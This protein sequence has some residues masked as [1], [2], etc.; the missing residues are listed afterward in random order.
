MTASDATAL[1]G[2]AGGEATARTIAEV[3]A[4]RPVLERVGWQRLDPVPDYYLTVVRERAEVIRPHIFLADGGRPGSPVF[5]GRVEDLPLVTSFGYR[6]IYSP[7]VRAILLA[8]G[9]VVGADGAEGARVLVDHLREVLAA[10]EADVV[11]LPNVPIDSALHREVSALRFP[12]RQA[13]QVE[14]RHWILQLPGSFDEFLSARTK[15]TRDNVKRD[16]K[17]LLRDHGDHLRLEIYDDAASAGI[18][19]RDAGAVAAKTYQQGLGVAFAASPLDRAL[20]LLGLEQGW[21]RVYVLYTGDT[22]VAFWPGA[23]WKGTCFVGT[24]GYD[25]E[26]ASYGVGTYLLMRVIESLCVEEGVHT[27][28]YGA[29]DADYKRRFGSD[30]WLEADHAI[31]AKRVRP[32]QVN[33]TRTALELGVRAAKAAAGRAGVTETLRRRWRARITSGGK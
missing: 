15:K 11:V 26:F 16:S 20:T 4:L 3:E 12:V 6:P 19:S 9:G 27:I 31:F 13:G 18:L 1:E 25:P 10:G 32:L 14:S 30:S 28:D 23:V 22:P 33:V 17:R 24:P 7:K 5:V 21:S 29:G 8:H 2:P